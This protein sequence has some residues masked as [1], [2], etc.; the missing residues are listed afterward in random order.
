MIDTLIAYR[1]GKRYGVDT[2]MNG[3]DVRRLRPGHPRAGALRGRHALT[4]AQITPLSSRRAI[5]A[6]R[7]PQQAAVDLGVVLAQPRPQPFDGARRIGEARAHVGHGDLADARVLDQLDVLARLVLRVLEDLGD[8][9][10]RPARHLELD[11]ARDQ[12]GERMHLRPARDPGVDLGAVAIAVLDLAPLAIAREPR[13][14]L[15]LGEAGEDL[16]G[17]AGNRDPLAVLAWDSGCAGR[18]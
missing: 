13:L 2:S 1:E 5:S 16:V 6:S 3:V 7:Q 12:V 18:R 17:R 10:D 14:A 8:G 4:P 9:V 15:Q 11:A